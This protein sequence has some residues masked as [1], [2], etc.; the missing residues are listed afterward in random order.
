M[1]A[2]R[3]WVLNLD[4]DLELGAGKTYTPSAAVLAAMEPHVERLRRELLGPDDVLVGERTPPGSAAGRP[5][6]AFCPTDRAERILR[7]AGAMPEPRP[8]QAVLRE[9][10]GRA[11]ASSL[12]PTLAD[13]VFERDLQAALSR[14]ARPPPSGL[15][16]SWRAK[17]AF[18][19]AGRGQRRI[20]PAAIGGADVAF[21]ETAIAEGGVQL[22]PDVRIER[23][24][25]IHG[26]LA[27][28]G[29]LQKGAVVLQECDR[30]GQWVRS[31]RPAPGE[32]GPEL[33]R[34]LV[35]ELSLV[36]SALA[37]V[38]YFGPF[39]VDAFEYRTAAGA[40]ALQ[41]RSEINARY[42]MGFAV[43]FGSAGP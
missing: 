8:T 18:G 1:A 19:M 2:G 3:A 24:L 41:P 22:E 7:Q 42:S 23:E 15:A 9:V 5:G 36:G 13:G 12:G 38:R 27:A 34:A 20:D 25:A 26:W 14:V 29:S 43:G 35:F 28:D 6:R 21:L 17:R 33:E 10:N 31:R 39:G 30:H 37:H 16:K 40:I 4:A 32:V 11:F